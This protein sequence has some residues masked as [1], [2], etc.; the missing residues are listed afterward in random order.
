MAKTSGNIILVTGGAGFIGSHIVDLLV[1]RKKRVLIVDNFS[2]GKKS[3]IDPDYL[4]GPN[5]NVRLL[6]KDISR[7]TERDLNGVTII[8]H[9]AFLPLVQHS[10]KYPEETER[11]NVGGTIHLLELSRKITPKKFI[12]ASSCVVYQ[13]TNPYA[14]QKLACE[15]YCKLYEKLYGIPMAILRYLNVYGPRQDASSSYS[16]VI[17]RFRKLKKEGKPFEIFGDGKQQRDFIAVEDIA[18]KTVKAITLKGVYDVGKGKPMS[19]NQVAD[20]IGGKDWPRKYLP[21]RKGEIRAIWAGKYGTKK[22]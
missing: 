12:F 21:A 17:A 15:E 18:K 11:N 3:N 5:P 19:V 1:R 14:V 6:K 16:G 9:L 20:W 10:L 7:L 22:L 8:I 13:I 2:T 4:K